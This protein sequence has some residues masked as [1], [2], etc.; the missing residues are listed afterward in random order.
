MSE[1]QQKQWEQDVEDYGDD[2]CSLYEIQKDYYEDGILVDQDWIPAECNYTVQEGL[3]FHCIRRKDSAALPFDLERAK[4][5]DEILAIDEDGK[6]HRA[7][8]QGY[9]EETSGIIIGLPDSDNE[10]AANVHKS[11]LRMKFPPKVKMRA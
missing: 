9:Y 7:I 10:R 2:A 1:E 11:S 5:G 4:A 3:K 8:Y 6:I